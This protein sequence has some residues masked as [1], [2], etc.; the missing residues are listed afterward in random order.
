M[1][2]TSALLSTLV[3]CSL[4][5]A[6]LALADDAG[7]WSQMKNKLERITPQKKTVS[8]TAV[9]GVRAAKDQSD[10]TLYWKDE[11]LGA[12]ISDAE[13]SSFKDAYQAVEAGKKDEASTKFADFIKAYPQS[14]LR[15][16]A[17]AAVKTLQSQK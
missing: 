9:G 11:D 15:S 10:E 6:G 8:T 5:T 16:D 14:P 7:V 4:F 2:R 1:K 12:R 17:E 13:L 3:A